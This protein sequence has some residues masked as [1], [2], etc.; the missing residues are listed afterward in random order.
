MVLNCDD[1]EEPDFSDEELAEHLADIIRE[2]LE[3]L[4]F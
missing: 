2:L 4:G 1:G 3:S